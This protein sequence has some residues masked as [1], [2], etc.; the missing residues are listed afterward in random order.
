[1]LR[2][3]GVGLKAGA[4]EAGVEIPG[5]ELAVLPELIRGHPSPSGFDLTARLLRHRRA[6]RD[7]HRRDAAAPGD[8]L[9]G[10]PSIGHPLQRL[11]ARPPG[12]ARGRRLDLDD[13]PDELGGA[14]RRR[15]AAR[16]DGHLRARGARA[17]ALGHRR[18]RARAHHRRRAAEPAA[19]A[20]R[21]RLRRSPTPLP[22]PPVFDA[23]R[24]LGGVG[25]GR[26][27]G[28]SSTWAAASCAVVPAAVGSRRGRAARAPPPGRAPDR[29]DHRRR[30]T[31]F[32]AAG[33]GRGRLAPGLRA[34]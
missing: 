14:T 18:A 19:A 34:A 4:E 2:A 11:L 12:A 30:W 6:R 13:R 26:R 9:I 5:G 10:L 16:A 29:H 33:R 8:A 24:A 22:V 3:I 25:A 27:C 21:R 23:D 1:M 32:G 15:R 20:R 28:R 7:R 17:A 31:V